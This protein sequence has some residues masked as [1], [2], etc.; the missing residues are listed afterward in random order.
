MPDLNYG[1]NK[2][3]SRLGCR[4]KPTATMSDA[5]DKFLHKN[6]FCCPVCFK[7]ITLWAKI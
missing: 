1:D 4:F 7:K 5:M 6:C 2:R 3:I